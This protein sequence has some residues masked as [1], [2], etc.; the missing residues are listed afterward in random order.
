MWYT[1]YRLDLYITYNIELIKKYVN[2]VR[3]ST[4]FCWAQ[5]DPEDLDNSW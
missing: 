4:N 3:L 1:W 5:L 2:C